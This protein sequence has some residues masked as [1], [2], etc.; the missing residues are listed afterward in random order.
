MGHEHQVALEG[1]LV[2][3]Q[4]FFLNNEITP[5]FDLFLFCWFE[6]SRSIIGGVL[7]CPSGKSSANTAAE[8]ALL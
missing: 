7:F 3:M 1:D 4:I 2:L 6:S 5:L 8:F